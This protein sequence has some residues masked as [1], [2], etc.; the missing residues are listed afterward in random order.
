MMKDKNLNLTS[1][2][3]ST[4]YQAETINVSGISYSDARQISLD[5]FNENF[6]KL[7]NVAAEIAI[8]RVEEFTE[9]LLKEIYQKNPRLINSIKD[10]GMLC[11]LYT[12]QKEYAKTGNKDLRDILIDILIQRAA[13]DTRSLKQ[14]VMDESIEVLQKLTSGQLDLM[15]IIFVIKQ[16]NIT[17]IVNMQNLLL[18]L[19]KYIKQFTLDITNKTSLCWHLVYVG[20]GSFTDG[21]NRLE[22]FLYNK[23]E[24]IFIDNNINKN[25]IRSFISSE[26]PFMEHLFN[27][28]TNSLIS[29]FSLTPVGINIAIANFKMKT[30][31]PINIDIWLN[32]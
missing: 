19:E 27:A 31:F 26:L 13:L 7:S 17:D 11:S 28:W 4:S 3:N 12:A 30:G 16:V 14:I 9:K 32:Q 24:K 22:E 15:T 2:D 29:R 6:L 1:G 21:E 5:V 18:F 8:K 10:P 20:C 25:Q 23:Y